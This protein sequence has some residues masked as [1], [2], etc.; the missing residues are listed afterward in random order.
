MSELAKS[1]A[2][3]IARAIQR[4]EVSPV[5]VLDGYVERI[6]SLNPALN[7]IVVPRLEQAREEAKEAEMA[8]SRG[9]ELGPLHGVPFTV[10]E[11]IEVEGMPCANASRLFE[12]NVS[13]ETAVV[14]EN[15]RDAGAILI[16]KT[17]VSEFCSFYDSVNLVYGATH[18]PHDPSRSAGG[19][20]GGEGAAVAS[21]MT[22]FGAGSD[23]GGS[24]RIPASW[25]GI[26][27]LKPGRGVVSTL[28]HFPR[29]GGISFQLMNGI[30]PI[31][32]F[33]EDLEL[34]L[35]VF[36]RPGRD[37]DVV[38]GA[39]L[40]A[41]NGKP[42]VAVFD[43]D[44]L[45][46]VAAVCRDAVRRAADAL[47]QAGYEVVEERPPNQ[48]ELR[49]VYDVVLVTDLAVTFLP[50][51]EGREAELTPYVREMVEQLRGN[52]AS[53][54]PY[55][56]AFDRLATFGREAA[57][58]FARHPVALSPVT[59]VPAPKL[60][61]GITEIDGEPPREGGKMTL[62]SYANALGLPAVSV[63]AGRTPEGLPLAVQLMGRRRGELEL[64]AVAKDLEQ[65]LGGWVRT[66][67]AGIAGA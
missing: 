61:E 17:N 28:G 47:A 14:V 37:P 13:T 63:P 20:S 52:P 27:G 40:A 56:A 39:L 60:G 64:L 62:C 22:A 32:R 36:A 10:K 1:S 45:Q 35:P 15:L 29:D 31:A 58:W 9:D 3:W 50:Q 65:A 18:N 24:I 51:V 26:F 12:G 49:Q 7:A 25:D 38:P 30:G 16:G 2:A 41:G 21:A 19:S 53:L 67:P 11:A 34:L 55:V 6:E 43:E 4:R 66:E 5:E 54:E 23:L 46:N 8:V 59:P 48:A 57:A 44:G 33:V 42:R